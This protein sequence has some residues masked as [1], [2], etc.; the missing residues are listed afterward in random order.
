MLNA[1]SESVFSPIFSDDL[2]FKAE[3]GSIHGSRIR[4]SEAMSSPR[5]DQTPTRVSRELLI[6][7]GNP[8]HIH[9]SFPVF[10]CHSLGSAVWPLRVSGAR[11]AEFVSSLHEEYNLLRIDHHEACCNPSQA[12]SH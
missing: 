5:M 10:V 1:R 3:F 6:P 7:G 11:C 9:C 12:F 2:F 4:L 8:V